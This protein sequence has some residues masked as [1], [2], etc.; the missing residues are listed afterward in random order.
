[1]QATEAERTPVK[2]ILK[3]LAGKNNKEYKINLER[4]EIKQNFYAV[5]AEID[6][7]HRIYQ[8]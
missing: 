5:K 4:K 8:I 1:M 2:T 3:V 6:A 7:R